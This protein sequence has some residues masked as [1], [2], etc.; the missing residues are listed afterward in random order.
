MWRI[1]L[2]GA[3]VL[4][5]AWALWQIDC[6]RGE[7]RTQTA[8]LAGA[9][10]TVYR[11]DA[12]PQDAPLAVVAHGFAGSRQMMR[13]VALTLARAG[14][15]VVTF[16]FIGHGRH[17]ALMSP[18][19]GDIDGTTA[20][21]VDQAVAVAR[22]ARALPG[23]AAQGPMILAGHSMATDVTI[24]A[25]QRLDGV[26]AIVAISMYS[27]TVTAAFPERLLIVSGAWEGRLRDVALRF[28]RQVDAD[29][30]EGE[31]AVSGEVRRRAVAA[32]GV[33]HVGVLYSPVTL[34]EARDWAAAA[35][36]MDAGTPTA[37][38]GLPVLALPLAAALAF[39]AVAPLA[40]PPLAPPPEVSRARFAAALA[41]PLLP[42]GAAMLALAGQGPVAGFVP[43]AAFLG[44]W[45]AVQLAVLWQ[46]GWRPGPVR[47]QALALLIGWG[48][49]FALVLDRAF[50]AFVPTGPRAGLMALLLVGAL[51]F[52][53]ADTAL[54]HG[55]ALWR[56]AL[57]RIVLLAV[58]A[59][60][61]IAAPRT[62]GL[63]FTVLP[64]LVLFFAVYGGFARAIAARAGATTAWVGTALALAWALAASTPLFALP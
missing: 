10:A 12:A 26:A 43:L 33:E 1:L 16:D 14:H 60:T 56:R 49:V 45:G 32:P 2:G 51:P 61:M 23:V 48:L 42:A 15:I 57:A 6:A 36:G 62:L 55:A 35:T 8:V 21:L 44:L 24:R 29:A 11:P 27:D 30:Q 63:I 46:G 13:A 40:G 19:V 50:S 25:A 39:A 38:I 53:L 31:T 4:V 28:L 34:A 20:Q 3:A 54:S 47:W 52:A 22:A 5:A 7:V 59:A 58:L 17:T 9:P 41:V 64:V 37:A 18:R